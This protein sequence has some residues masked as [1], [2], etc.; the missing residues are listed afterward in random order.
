MNIIKKAFVVASAAVMCAIPLAPSVADNTTFFS[1][2]SIIADAAD[3]TTNYKQFPTATR[4]NGYY[5]SWVS[6]REVKWIQAAI[7]NIKA[8]YGVNTI[9]YLDV[10]GYYG[11]NTTYAVTMIQRGNFYKNGKR[12]YGPIAADGYAGKNTQAKIKYLLNA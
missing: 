5:E 9:N 3:Y 12:I 10:D 7:N 4:A 8:K 2:N 1:S 6:Y 11:Q